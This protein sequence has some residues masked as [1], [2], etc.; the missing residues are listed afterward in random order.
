[1]AGPYETET[2]QRLLDAAHEVFSESGY[3]GASI[4]QIVLKAGA[5]VASVNYHFG[6]KDA[7]Y[8]EVVEATMAKL[9][10]DLGT[11]MEQSEPGSAPHAVI[12][13]FAKQRLKQGALRKRLFPPRLIGWE[14]VSPK[15]NVRNLFE[16]RFPKLEEKL[17]VLLS[18]LFTPDTPHAR[19][20]LIARWFFSNTMPP[21]PVGM[22]LQSMLGPDPDAEELDRA[23]GHLADAV[24][25]GLKVLAGQSDEADGAA[26]TAPE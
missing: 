9:T 26:E 10:E 2:R 7:L 13:N 5:N 4:R 1:M 11:I 23:V 18:P 22:A 8:R 16:K 25:A 15:L 19:K 17:L 14:I 6:G 21:P 20:V 3:D 12:R 24:L